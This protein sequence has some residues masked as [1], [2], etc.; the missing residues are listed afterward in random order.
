MISR[1]PA[2][3]NIAVLNTEVTNLNTSVT[4]IDTRFT[5]TQYGPL[6]NT[7][8]GQNYLTFGTLVAVTAINI[9]NNVVYYTPFYLHSEMTFDRIACRSGTQSGTAPARLGLYANNNGKPGN[10]ILD[11]G[12][13]VMTATL[14][15]YEITINQTLPAGWY[16][17]AFVQQSSG[18]FSISVQ[19]STQMALG[20][21]RTNNT[22]S[23]I[24]PSLAQTGVS[25]NLPFTAA[26]S[27]DNISPNPYVFMRYNA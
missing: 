5:A 11:A 20:A 22:L 3:A 27:L 13:V 10:L 4:S 1:D 21:A 23:A 25:G 7:S 2:V 18:T 16:W 19:G 17:F 14:T 15:T 9:P 26:T 8:N 6:P 12:T 24:Q